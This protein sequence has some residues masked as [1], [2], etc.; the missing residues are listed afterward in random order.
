MKTPKFIFM[1]AVVLSAVSCGNN[2]NADQKDAVIT[3]STAT[4][5]TPQVETP[6]PTPPQ[7]RE[8]FLVQIKKMEGEMFKAAELDNTKAND[9]IKLYTDF[10]LYFPKDTLSPEYLF[11]A[12]EVATA[13]KKYKRALEQYET[14]L[15][16]YPDYK[17][18]KE[19]MYLKAF[20]LDNFLNDDA[21]AKL[22]YEEVISKYPNT[23]YAKDAR[24]AIDN[25][26]KT[27][28]QLMEEI[29]KKNQKK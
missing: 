12:G 17:H 1:V 27:D 19:T 16:K 3:D 29:K 26:G 18:Y 25:L 28:E 10:A 15:S 6:P 20:L 14:I 7:P 22:V 13:S 11:K 24:S 8:E 9:A 5:E 23:N 21:A 2:E 4:V